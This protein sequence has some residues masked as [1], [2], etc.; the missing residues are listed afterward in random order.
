MEIHLRNCDKQTDKCGC[1]NCT[2]TG[3]ILSFDSKKSEEKIKGIAM[4]PK[5]KSTNLRRI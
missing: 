4:C 3:S 2:Y 1:N 5:C